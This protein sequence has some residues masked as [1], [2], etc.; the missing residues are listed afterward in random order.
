MGVTFLSPI[1]I[2]VSEKEVRVPPPKIV[3]HFQVRR[4]VSDPSKGERSENKNIFRA[5]PTLS[6]CLVWK[7]SAITMNVMA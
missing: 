4:A 1:S 3:Y 7:V 6:G 5:H 2:I